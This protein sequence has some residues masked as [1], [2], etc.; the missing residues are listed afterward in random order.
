[1]SR[2]DGGPAYPVVRGKHDVLSR[3]M[4]LLDW[5]AGM[6][7]QGLI[8]VPED[9]AIHPPTDAKTAFELADA[10]IKERDRAEGVESKE[11]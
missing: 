8:S 11:K 6:A 5:F 4:T 10:M 7:L 2:N 9:G 1:M 3:G